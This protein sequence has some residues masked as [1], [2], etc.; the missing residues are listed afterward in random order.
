MPKHLY[1][2]TLLT[3]LTG[4]ASGIF[5]YF[6]TRGDL[7]PQIT[8][9]DTKEEKGYDIVA[10]TYG[11]CERVGCA[12][13]RFKDDGSYVY[14]V[15]DRNGEYERFEDRIS[16]KQRETLT[17]L[18][19]DTPLETVA[20]TPYEGTCP[21]TYDGVAYRFAIRVGMESYDIDSCV[22]AVEGVPLF[23]TLTEYFAIMSATYPTQ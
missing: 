21:A 2:L 23:D 1:L 14:L 17:K 9:E 13:I 11:G 18:L 16:S 12:S 20:H 5:V 8:V 6:E 10:T 19:N 22:S 3:F 15:N 7:L 4:F